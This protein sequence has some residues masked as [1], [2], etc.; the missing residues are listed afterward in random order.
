MNIN[1]QQLLVVDKTQHIIALKGKFVEITILCH[2]DHYCIAVVD[3]LF[4]Q[5]CDVN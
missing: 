2:T 4:K 1:P 5:T 3:K